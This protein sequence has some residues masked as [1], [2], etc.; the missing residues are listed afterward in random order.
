MIGRAIISARSRSPSITWPTSWK[1]ADP[2]HP[3]GR[4]LLLLTWTGGL[5]YVLLAA[6]APMVQDWFALGYV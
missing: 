4:F 1:T 5:P 3:A 6:T 2:G